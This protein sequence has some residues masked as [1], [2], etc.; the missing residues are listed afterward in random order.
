[1]GRR[2]ARVTRDARRA[3]RTWL[4]R[5]PTEVAPSLLG[6]L[7]EANGVVGRIVE[8]EAYREDDPASH[9]HR[10]R[11]GANGTMFGPAGLLYVYL[12]HGLHHCANVVVGPAG[13]GAAVLVR[14]VE[15]VE[16][17]D[18]AIARRGR[19]SDDP[20]VLGGGPGRVGQ[21]LG[22]SRE[23]DGHDLLGPEAGPRLLDDGHAVG[24]IASGPRVGVRLGADAA[25]RWWVD[26]SAAVSRYR[27]H[28]GARSGGGDA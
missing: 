7:L 24:R 10:G 20:R 28:P 23:H 26:G 16:G 3:P 17:R 9:S 14:A 11:T 4:E 13:V 2:P 5:D 21:L 22:L 1:M 8:V 12:S 25:W 27:R 15:V 19:G 6:L 18:V